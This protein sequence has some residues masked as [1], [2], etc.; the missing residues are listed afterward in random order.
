MPA[1]NFEELRQETPS[2]PSEAIRA[3]VEAA[4][5][6]Q[7]E[8]GVDCNAHLAGQALRDTCALDGA[9]A[10]LM[11]TAYEMCIRDRPQ[12][13]Q[14]WRTRNGYA[15][16]ALENRERLRPSG[17]W[18]TGAVPAQVQKNAP[19]SEEP[20]AWGRWWSDCLLY[21]SRCV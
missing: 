1:L 13:C 17:S 8:R 14:L 16:P 3:R 15:P 21:T 9:G 20:G 4:R 5:R 11:K 2:E 19:G 10:A 7:L 12:P 6:L 18:R